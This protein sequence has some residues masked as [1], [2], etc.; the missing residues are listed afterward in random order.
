MLF[1]DREYDREFINAGVLTAAM[2]AGLYSSLK[3]IPC[4]AVFV[5]QENNLLMDAF[6]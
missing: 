1:H 4:V 5:V 3:S 6:P 2:N